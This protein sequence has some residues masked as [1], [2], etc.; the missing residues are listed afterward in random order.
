MD[1]VIRHLADASCPN[2]FT[3]CTG[4]LLR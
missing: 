2:W 4:T 1:M 3:V